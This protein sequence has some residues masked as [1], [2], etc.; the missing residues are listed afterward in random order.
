MNHR[1]W[2]DFAAASASQPDPV[3]RR[4]QGFTSPSK[5]GW[6]EYAEDVPPQARAEATRRHILDA[7]VA[8]FKERGFAGTNLNQLIR[9]AGVTPGAFYYHFDSK[10]EVAFAI[11]DEVAQRMADLRTTFVGVPE[12]GLGNVIL[13]TFQLSALLQNDPSFWVAAHLEHTMARHCQRGIA[14]VT[15]RIDE[16]VAGVRQAIPASQLR[17]GVD[18]A[19]AATTMVNLI[20]G[21]YMM[22]DLL[23]GD[24]ASRLAECWRI[25]LPGLVPPD[26]LPQFERIVSD[27][28][29]RGRQSGVVGA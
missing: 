29:A 3:V 12:S 28:L 11:I 5:R 23:L 25:L 15:E 27:M 8:L 9:K 22:T 26:L 13:M 17:A 24:T 4:C 10:E 16:F 1:R 21:S 14:G 7:A 2:P 20:Y 6:P 19:Q 18:P